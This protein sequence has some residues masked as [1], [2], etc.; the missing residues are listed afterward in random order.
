M[1]GV[2][3]SVS[4]KD[5]S[6]AERKS[7]TDVQTTHST[8]DIRDAESAPSGLSYNDWVSSDRVLTDL[9]ARIEAWHAALG[10]GNTSTRHHTV[11]MRRVTIEVRS[12]SL[13]L[14]FVIV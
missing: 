10:T 1:E 12:E 11:A 3:K 14:I 8:E 9:E 6:G 5:L 7:P 13:L 4:L 2:G